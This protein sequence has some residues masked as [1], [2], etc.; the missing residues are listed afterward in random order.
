[1]ETWL[2][3]F[4]QC[5]AWWGRHWTSLFQPERVNSPNEAFCYQ[6]GLEKHLCFSGLLASGNLCAV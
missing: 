1:L 5:L 4:R 6:Q 2:L 3:V